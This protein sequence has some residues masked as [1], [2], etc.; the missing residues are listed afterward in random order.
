VKE[1]TIEFTKRAKVS[2][3]LLE[4]K[5][6]SRVTGAIELLKTDPVPPKAKRLSGTA[7]YRIR[8]G[9]LRIIYSFSGRRLLILVLDIGHRKEIYRRD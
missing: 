6:Q 5:E 1:Y 2:L 8:V 3:K 7:N 9:N 4:K